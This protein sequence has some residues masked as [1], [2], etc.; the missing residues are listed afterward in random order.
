MKPNKQQQKLADD[1]RLLRAWRKWYRE[2]LE[3]ALAGVHAAVFERLMTQLKDL[4][5]ARELVD[6]IAAQDWTAVD[7]D[8]RL[9][10]QHQINNAITAL[11]ERSGLTPIDDPLPGQPENAFRIIKTIMSSFPPNA[12]K[13]T[14]VSSVNDRKSVR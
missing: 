6:F 9:I 13:H 4:H 12:G 11:R 7:S 14:E 8:T 2:Q 10:A 5:S 3:D 1:A